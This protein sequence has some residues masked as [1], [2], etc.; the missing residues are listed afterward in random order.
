MPL[1]KTLP[2][3]CPR[4]GTG[5]MSHACQHQGKSREGHLQASPTITLEL[6]HSTA[7]LRMH[8]LAE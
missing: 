5:V 2:E 1:G 4:L 7:L 8:L 6:P 3:E